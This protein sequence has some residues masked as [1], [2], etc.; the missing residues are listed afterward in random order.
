MIKIFYILFVILSLLNWCVFYTQSI[1]QCGSWLL[2]QTVFNSSQRFSVVPEQTGLSRPLA[3]TCMYGSFFLEGSYLG[4]SF[5]P[6]TNKAYISSPKTS[7]FQWLQVN[8]SPYL[9]PSRA[10]RRSELFQNFSHSTIF[11]C[12]FFLAFLILANC[13]SSTTTL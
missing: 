11:F 5:A 7:L 10:P 13:L 4:C 1:Y 3:S 6:F 12:L 9:I 8:G 2:Y